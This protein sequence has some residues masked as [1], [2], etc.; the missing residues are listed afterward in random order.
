MLRPNRNGELEFSDLES[1]LR[2]TAPGLFDGARREAL[3]SR[4]LSSLG[5]QERRRS[6]LPVVPAGRWVAV[7]LA[8]GLAVAVVAVSWPAAGRIVVDRGAG[9]TDGALVMRHPTTVLSMTNGVQ[10]DIA[11]GGRARLLD[12]GPVFRLALDAGSGTFSASGRQMEVMGSGWTL[13]MREGVA[14]V[15]SAGQTATVTVAEGTVTVATPL[16]VCTAVNG[17]S[18]I[19]HAAGGCETVGAGPKRADGERVDSPPNGHGIDPGETGPPTSP[20]GQENPPGNGTPPT[21][22]PGQENPP[23]NGAPPTAPPGP[24]NPPGNGTPPTAP[25]GQENLPGN[26][27]PPASPP[28][29]GNPPGNGAPPTSPPGQENP[30]GNGN[31]T[32]PGQGKR[33][34]K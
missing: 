3:R 32:P 14:S 6:W 27:T 2:A 20:P 19:V 16:G 1:A 26:G 17:Q 34:E 28:G 25:P 23:G 8:A 21:A 22:P 29:Q 10:A 11:S 5:E 13:T 33:P 18:I 24:E 15:V 4:I 9:T 31:G 7:P 30:P 12:D